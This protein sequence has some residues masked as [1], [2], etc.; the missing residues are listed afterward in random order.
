MKNFDLFEFG[1]SEKREIYA[2]LS[3]H[4]PNTPSVAKMMTDALMEA[5]KDDDFRT[6]LQMWVNKTT[7]LSCYQLEVHGISLSDMI[8]KFIEAYPGQ[9]RIGVITSIYLLWIE[10]TDPVRR[11]L[12]F[13][14]TELCHAEPCVADGSELCYE[15]ELFEDGWWFISREL[16]LAEPDGEVVESSV[17]E[18]DTWLILIHNPLLFTALGVELPIGTRLIFSDKEKAY[19]VYT[20]VKEE[21]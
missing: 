9:D 17:F 20:P 7:D 12:C 18:Y 3:A 13:F 15:A 14:L 19:I 10:K 2:L 16:S 21:L 5:S 1:E 8:S 4:T 11:G 6:A